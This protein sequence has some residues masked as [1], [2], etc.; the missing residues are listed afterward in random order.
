MGDG[1]GI[2]A[3]DADRAR[4]GDVPRQPRQHRAG[5]RRRLRRHA[6]G[7]PPAVPD[8]A[9]PRP[10]QPQH[11][12]LPGQDHPQHRGREHRGPGHADRRGRLGGRGRRHLEGLLLQQRRAGRRRC[13]GI[14]HGRLPAVLGGRLLHH[15]PRRRH[16]ARAVADVDRGAAGRAGGRHLGRPADDVP[17]RRRRLDRRQLRP[18]S[19][20]HL[21]GGGAGQAVGAG[22]PA[23][24][25][26]RALHQLDAGARS[27]D[28]RNALVL[29]APAGRVA[30]HGRDVRAHPRRRR[31][32]ALGFHDGQAGHP[33]A[34]RPRDR[35]VRQRHRPRLPEH[36][37]HRCPRPDACRSGP[38]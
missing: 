12:D 33:V 1:A 11:R 37:G 35:R 7:V 5:A 2:A 10:A 18:G 19:R 14:R 15:R 3:D 9:G 20:P 28:G 23:H 27:R 21:L 24:R 8:R 17:R 31:R 30:R 13:G 38:A 25:R 6:V 4:G 29:P 16:R 26:G 36:R 22:E 32:P 34:A